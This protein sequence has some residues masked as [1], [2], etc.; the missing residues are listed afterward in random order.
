MGWALLLSICPWGRSS[1]CPSV[2]GV[3]LPAV[4]LSLVWAFPLSISPWGG[5]S[6]CPSVP[7]VGFPAVHLSLGWAFPLSVCLLGRPS[8]C[9]SVHGWEPAPFLEYLLRANACRSP[10]FSY[11]VFCSLYVKPI[12]VCTKWAV[13]P[14]TLPRGSCYLNLQVKLS[15][16]WLTQLYHIK[17]GVSGRSISAC[18]PVMMVGLMSPGY[19]HVRKVI[20][21]LVEYRTHILNFEHCPRYKHI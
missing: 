3:G 18:S 1:R 8:R 19:F 5:P 11:P 15:S 10:P 16:L 4:H 17:G 12:P 14:D 7:G 9:P 13:C 20:H 2:P 6:C 21:N